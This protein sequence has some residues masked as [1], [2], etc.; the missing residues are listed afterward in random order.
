MTIS[1]INAT[2]ATVT[3]KTLDDVVGTAGTA[4]T[5]PLTVQGISG[6]TAVPVSFTSS[7]LPTGASTE[8]TLAAFSTATHAD[9]IAATPAGTNIIGKVGIDQTTPGTTNA[10]VTTGNVASGTTDSGNGLK[11]SGL[12]TTTPPTVTTGQRV[13][14]QLSARGRIVNELTQFGLIDGQSNANVGSFPAA[15]LT[16]VPLWVASS[17]FN[18]TTWDRTRGDA[19]GA[20]VQ[21]A[22]SSTFWNYAAATGGI[23]NT[24]TAVTIKA[25]AGASVRNYL[26]SIQLAS[27]TLGAATEVAI[28]DGAAGTVLWRGKMQTASTATTDIVFN[29]PLRGTANTLM[30]VVTLTA[31]V[32]GGVYVNA[33]GYTGV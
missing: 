2:G 30:E 29:P 16:A 20:V 12:F 14:L 31:T 5:N 27:D 25:A 21:P 28:R 9:L 17:V 10:V 6:G 32:T 33:Q 11:I 4:N 23:V 1:V 22:L 24:T 3:A 18:G 8:A 26:N 13:D 15:G 7:P 19:N